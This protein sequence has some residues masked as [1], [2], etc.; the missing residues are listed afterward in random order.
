MERAERMGRASQKQKWGS[1]ERLRTGSHSPSQDAFLLPTE[2]SAAKMVW[3]A[4]FKS[5]CLP[6]S[7]IPKFPG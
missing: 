5:I 7:M 3:G 6:A 1:R 2:V 4:S